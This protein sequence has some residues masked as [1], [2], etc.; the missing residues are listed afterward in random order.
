MYYD[1]LKKSVEA[2]TRAKTQ[3]NAPRTSVSDHIAPCFRPV[4]EDIRQD[5]HT[6]YY[7]PGGRGS[8]KSSFCA[9][10]VVDGIMQDK[11][12][13]AIVFRKY[14]NTLRES[15]FSQIQWAIDELGAGALWKSN[16][17]PMVYTYIPTGQ[18]IFFRGLDDA[19]KLKSIRPRRGR[20]AL[21]WFEEFSEMDGPNQVRSVLQSVMR[22]GDSFKVF[23]SFNPP[24]SRANW[25]NKY[26]LVPDNR[27]MVHKSTYTDLPP[28][29]LGESFLLEAQRLND[30]N[31]RAYAHE[32][33]GEPIGNGGEVFP[34]LEI[35]TIT[36]NEIGQ[37]QY[38]YAGLDFGFSVDPAA[39]IRVSY[40]HKRQ[41]LYLLNE[42]Y[43]RGL[44]NQALAHAIIDGGFNRQ[45]DN[46]GGYTSPF[47]GTHTPDRQNIFCDSAEPKSIA[48][49]RGAGINARPC[50]KFPGSVLYGIRWLQSKTIV[51]DPARTPNAYREFSEYEYSQT[52][53]GDLLADVPDKNNH[54]IDAVRYACTQLISRESA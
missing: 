41:T 37:M 31:P 48:D 6:L 32:Y 36:D 19:Q 39:F 18:Q 16:I 12:A 20:F 47:T 13:N 43:K 49:L 23:C 35:R 53:D 34:N 30:I 15:V 45:P 28:E 44:T 25:A 9:L 4:H 46:S 24:I 54:T 3:Y 33:L 7:L 40:D 14:A 22:G 27:A 42:I 51:I 21:I 52:K 1:R 11:T 50:V 5:A 29:W 2:Y 26:I 10:E 8:G 17:S 38:Y